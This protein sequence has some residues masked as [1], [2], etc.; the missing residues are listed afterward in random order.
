MK[1]VGLKI[2]R[3]KLSEYVGRAAC[4]ETVLV[5]DR[6]RVA[7]ALVP[8][9]PD[10]NPFPS[11]PVLADLVRAGLVIPP[12]HSASGLPPRTPVVPFEDLMKEIDRD[13][14]DR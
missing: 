5:T 9:Q 8:P 10:Y 3:N 13:R 1:S 11:D 4:G 6:G 2:L 12:T 14:R 7:A